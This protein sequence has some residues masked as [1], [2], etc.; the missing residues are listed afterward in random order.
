MW[1]D[2]HHFVATPKI[3]NAHTLA[4][5][6]L[7]E[8]LKTIMVHIIKVIGINPCIFAQFEILNLAHYV[9][10]FQATVSVTHHS[11]SNDHKENI[12][13]KT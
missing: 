5:M 12:S 4:K 2:S 10:C 11:Q 7:L 1:S 9:A 3:L 8:D 6:S 13:K